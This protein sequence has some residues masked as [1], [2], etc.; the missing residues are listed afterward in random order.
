VRE[1]AYLP[2]GGG[3]PEHQVAYVNE[4]H[5]ELQD[6][7]GQHEYTPYVNPQ[8]LTRQQRLSTT[9]H[10]RTQHGERERE[11]QRDNENDGRGHD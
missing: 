7:F 1:L 9:Q 8:Q 2:E 6:E 5:A 10:N 3:D 11:R 4:L